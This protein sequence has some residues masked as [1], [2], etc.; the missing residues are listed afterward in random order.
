MYAV[1]PV[2]VNWLP[3]PAGYA[4]RQFRNQH[5]KSKLKTVTF[6]FFALLAWA[7]K[8][9]LRVFKRIFSLPKKF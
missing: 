1:K 9:L 8:I 3:S 4:S 7:G 6:L 2:D 5:S